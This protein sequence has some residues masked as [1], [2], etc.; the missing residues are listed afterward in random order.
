MFAWSQLDFS[1]IPVSISAVSLT[2]RQVNSKRRLQRIQNVQEEKTSEKRN[3][4]L[5]QS[6]FL[7]FLG[8]SFQQLNFEC[9]RKKL[10]AGKWKENSQ[11]FHEDNYLPLYTVTRRSA[12]FRHPARMTQD[13]SCYIGEND[14]SIQ[15][16]NLL[17]QPPKFSVDNRSFRNHRKFP[18]IF[19][20]KKCRMR[21][22]GSNSVPLAYQSCPLPLDHGYHILCVKNIQRYQRDWRL[23]RGLIEWRWMN[24]LYECD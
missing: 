16:G 3:I 7:L 4:K 19:T 15:S 18:A 21:M 6:L 12:E 2:G 5:L 8:R 24:V 1:A 10:L 22:M 13:S 14:C 11:M 23:E 9:Y 20:M 17:P